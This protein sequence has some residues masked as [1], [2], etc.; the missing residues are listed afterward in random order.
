MKI[1]HQFHFYCRNQIHLLTLPC[2]AVSLPKHCTLVWGVENN[3]LIK[4]NELF[5]HHTTC[6]TTLE[7]ITF[8][9]AI[10]HHTTNQVENDGRILNYFDTAVWMF[11]SSCPESPSEHPIFATLEWTCEGMIMAT[12]ALMKT[13]NTLNANL[14]TTSFY[15]VFWVS[16]CC[17]WNSRQTHLKFTSARNDVITNTVK[18]G[19]VTF[20]SYLLNHKWSG[21]KIGE[22]PEKNMVK[23]LN[24]L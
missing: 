9:R 1:L 7:T 5:D 8:H 19:K 4:L 12:A 11:L 6:Y 3:H 24:K 13:G 23:Y 22:V 20:R 10:T 21:Q 14:S 16:V 18:S 17:L 2:I 15:I